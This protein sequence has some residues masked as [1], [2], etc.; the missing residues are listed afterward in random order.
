[1]ISV[2]SV[3]I[4][5]VL[6]SEL[7]GH[8][9]AV[10]VGDSITDPDGLGALL[11]DA[12]AGEPA[13]GVPLYKGSNGRDEEGSPRILILSDTRLRGH[14]S[15]ALDPALPRRL[16][17]LTGRSLSRAPAEYSSKVDRRDTDLDMLRCMIGR[18][19]RPCWEV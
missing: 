19:Y 7:S 15:W 1:M 2:C 9:V 13:A 10:A 3:L 16:P 11:G 4:S 17:V 14:N 5:L 8:S 12:A 6:F 18:V